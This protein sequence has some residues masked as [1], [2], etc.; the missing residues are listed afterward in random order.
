M[1]LKLKTRKEYRVRRHRRVRRKISGT[2]ARPRMAIMKSDRHLYV[3]F[4]D[5]EQGRTLASASSRGNEGRK[6]LATAKALGQRAAAAAQA[7][8]VKLVVVDRGGFP[9][10]GRVKAI[11]DAALEAGLTT[12]SEEAS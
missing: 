9:F 12:S 1:K 2:A 11:V 3:Q 10:H 5:D 4:I 7:E 6:N 8:G